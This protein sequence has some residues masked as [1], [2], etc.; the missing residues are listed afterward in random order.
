LVPAR[1]AFHHAP[2]PMDGFDHQPIFFLLERAGGINQQ[3]AGFKALNC[4]TQEGDLLTMQ[5]DQV[6]RLQ[7]PLDFRIAP[8]GAGTGARGV[9]QD[10]VE[11]RRGKAKAEF[12]PAP[13]AGS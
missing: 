5:V 3:T 12:H 13:R 4:I 10:A 8:Q 1:Q 9:H 6:G 2:A 11:P 7:T